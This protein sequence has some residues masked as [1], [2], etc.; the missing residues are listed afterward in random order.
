LRGQPSGVLEKR[1]SETP[2]PEGKK[3]PRWVKTWKE[4]T[5]ADRLKSEARAGNSAKN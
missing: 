2:V 1:S 5:V 4:E 3:D